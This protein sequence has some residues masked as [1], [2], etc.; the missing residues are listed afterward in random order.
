LIRFHLVFI[1]PRQTG[2]A[3]RQVCFNLSNYDKQSLGSE[4]PSCQLAILATPAGRG[5]SAN[6]ARI[7]NNNANWPQI[8]AHRSHFP[9]TKARIS[10]PYLT[11]LLGLMPLTASSALLLWGRCAAMLRSSAL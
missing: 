11:S 1:S 2:A 4:H 7:V 8:R 6:A 10:D 9:I 3:T 5:G